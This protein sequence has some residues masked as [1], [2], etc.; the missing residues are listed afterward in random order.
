[1]NHMYGIP[2][3]TEQLVL[4][5]QYQF[6]TEIKRN[7]KQGDHIPHFSSVKQLFTYRQNCCVLM[8]N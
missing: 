8:T 6:T 2:M 1:M 5:D 4:N 7:M 3:N